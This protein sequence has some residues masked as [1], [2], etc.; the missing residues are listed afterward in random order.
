VS[1]R[2]IAFASVCVVASLTSAQLA[3][4]AGTANPVIRGVTFTGRNVDLTV[5]I[6]GA[7]FGTAPKGVPCTNCTT[8]YLHITDGRGYGCQM[9][10]IKS[11]TDTG[12]TFDGFQGNPGDSV[13]VLVKNPDDNLVGIRG[14]I[15]I[16]E[17]ITLATPK[18]KS[19]SF[20]GGAGPDL[21]MTIVG[22]GFGAS[23]PGLPLNGDLPF[24]VFVGRPFA[25]AE[26]HAGYGKGK[27]AD[28]VTL[29]YGT[30]SNN[31]I[32]ILGFGN[33]YGMNNWK[34]GR[35]DLVEIAA[36]NSNSCGLGMNLV[37]PALGPTFLGAVWIGRLP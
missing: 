28:A 11:W 20:F 26:W 13:L 16:P 7:G 12:I 33:A 19:V 5:K 27:I 14:E 3:V 18:I 29:T 30:W 23:P 6:S 34:V 32:L 10:N 2:R 22:S 25:A 36:A 35:G 1:S 4:A 8:R 15:N 24:F 31:R 21:E 37:T 17:T 9:F